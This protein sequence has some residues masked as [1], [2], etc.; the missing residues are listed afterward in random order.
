MPGSSVTSHRRQAII[1]V[2]H[3]QR[4]H[5][6]DVTSTRTSDEPFLRMQRL[7]REGMLSSKAGQRLNLGLAGF[8]AG[9]IASSIL[10]VGTLQMAGG[11]AAAA[12]VGATL[13]VCSA[14]L[15][16]F[17]TVQDETWAKHTEACTLAGANYAHISPDGLSFPSLAKVRYLGLHSAV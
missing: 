9:A 13:G 14:L 1:R 17:C 15:T 16:S 10:D 4:V 7:D 6:Y 11:A 12:V 3:A 8:G 2:L 5:S